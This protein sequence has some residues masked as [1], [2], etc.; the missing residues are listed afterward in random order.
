MKNRKK[1]PL[2]FSI[3]ELDRELIVRGSQVPEEKRFNFK[4]KEG[5]PARDAVMA[6]TKEMYDQ[7]PSPGEDFVHISSWDIGKALKIKT[8][9]SI[10]FVRGKWSDDLMEWY[11]ITDEQIKKHAGCIAA[12]VTKD[13]LLAADN[14]DFLLKVK[15][16]GKTFNLCHSEPFY[17]QPVAAG[18]IC[19]GF[20]VKEDIIATAGHCVNEENVT[21]LRVVFGFRMVDSTEPVTQIPGEDIYRGVKI[22][23]RA[24]HPDEGD[25]VL[26]QLDRKVKEQAVLKLAKNEVDDDQEIYVFGH[27]LGLPLKYSE[28]AYV[29][30]NTQ[31]SYFLANLD[32]YSGNCGSPVFD[33]YSGEVIG[34]VIDES[35]RDFRF[36]KDCWMSIKSPNNEGVRCSRV[37]R[38][39]DIAAQ[40]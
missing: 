19:T 26:V 28:G 9:H 20:L 11:E 4:D 2:E 24:C 37:S 36:V 1:S 18:S 13:S 39:V 27:P 22:I 31:K 29:V 14:D 21:D 12:V 35:S 33:S 30:D 17:D 40:L 16:Y 8:T 34:I 7:A 10:T 6:K 25:W 5:T 15:P 3:E 38:L 23:G 32:V